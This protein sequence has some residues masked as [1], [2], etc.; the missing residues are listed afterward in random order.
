MLVTSG[1]FVF[2]V[3]I[4]H[5][6]VS[7]T[8]NFVVNPVKPERQR[9]PSPVS[10]KP[11]SRAASQ[12]DIGADTTASAADQ[13][14]VIYATPFGGPP[15]IIKKPSAGNETASTREFLDIPQAAKPKASTSTGVDAR[16]FQ[17]YMTS[18]TSHTMPALNIGSS[19]YSEIDRPQ[20]PKT[21]SVGG[22]SSGKS[23][24]VQSPG[25]YEYADPNA[26]GKWSLQHIARGNPVE[27]VYATIPDTYGDATYSTGQFGR[28]YLVVLFS[29]VFSF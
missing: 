8:G 21:P 29:F 17:Q 11:G 28:N 18:K 14:T 26:V 23:G 1:S 27:C 15:V 12:S 6:L 16:K 22:N 10:P 24:S 2:V 13:S 7:V 9:K 19:A 5:S 25:P 4:T 3:L 20:H